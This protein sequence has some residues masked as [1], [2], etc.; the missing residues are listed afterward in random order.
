MGTVMEIYLVGLVFWSQEV[1]RDWDLRQF[2]VFQDPPLDSSTIRISFSS[3]SSTLRG[4]HI[5]LAAA[6]ALFFPYF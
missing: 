1:E 2:E 6:T 3:A 4:A 5:C